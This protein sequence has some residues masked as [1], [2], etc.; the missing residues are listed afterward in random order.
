MSAGAP[1]IRLVA[2]L[3]VKNEMGRY[4]RPNI[5]HLL[6]FCD[7]IRVLDDGSSDGGT[8]YLDGFNRVHVAGNEGHTFFEHE[9]EARNALLSWTMEAEPTHILAIDADEFVADGGLLRAELEADPTSLV[10]PLCMMEVWEADEKGVRYRLDGGWQPHPVPI[11]YR[12]PP[13]RD[14]TWRI[15]E[16]KLAC[17]REPMAVRQSYRHRAGAIPTEILHFGWANQAERQARYERYAV[18]DGGRFHQST[19]LQSILW[20]PDKTRL[21]DCPWPP[22]LEPLK[23]ILTARV[24]EPYRSPDDSSVR[25]A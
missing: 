16:R 7:E 2:S 1:P 13:V 3:I 9:G 19:H 20:G 17:G 4:L 8:E 11:L 22:G 21:C 24:A 18:A 6:D 12:V 25:T 23:P 15:A 5:K 14:N 10:W